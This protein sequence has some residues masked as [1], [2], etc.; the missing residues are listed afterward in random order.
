[1]RALPWAKHAPT[2]PFQE[3]LLLD[4]FLS[5][6]ASGAVVISQADP[7][8]IAKALSPERCGRQPVAFPGHRRT[9]SASARLNPT[10][11]RR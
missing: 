4:V 8:Y 6:G 1:M 10:S 11:S 2:V 9:I 7:V 3:I 5:E